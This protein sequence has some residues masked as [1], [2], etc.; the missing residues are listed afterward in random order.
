MLV[1]IL[2]SRHVTC[3]SASF[4]VLHPPA[5]SFIVLQRGTFQHTSNISHRH[6]SML[7]RVQC[8]TCWNRCMADPML[9]CVQK[10]CQCNKS[11]KH[12]RKGISLTRSNFRSPASQ[13]L[14][15]RG[16]AARRRPQQQ[17]QPL[18]HMQ[19]PRSSSATHAGCAAITCKKLTCSGSITGHNGVL[20]PPR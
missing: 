16:L 18:L 5:S 17:R 6:K 13:H 14:E 20:P 19:R 12:A 2:V 9:T 11:C 3:L 15:E 7:V 8:N 10:Q 1:S 4:S